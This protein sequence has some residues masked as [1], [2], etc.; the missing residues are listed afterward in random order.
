MGKED[1][2]I[3]FRRGLAIEWYNKN[4]VLAPGE[5]GYEEDTGLM[6]VGDGVSHWTT[7]DYFMEDVVT[8]VDELIE[9]HVESPHPH[10][11]YDDGPSLTLLYLNAKV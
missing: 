2:V 4:P 11:A 5:P 3:K 9:E 7:L 8:P 6:K 10:P 1:D